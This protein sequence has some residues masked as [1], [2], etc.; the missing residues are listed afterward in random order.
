MF[1]NT[2][3]SIRPKYIFPL[4]CDYG[5]YQVEKNRCGKPKDVHAHEPSDR[6]CVCES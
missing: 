2:R 3:G 5:A 1:P 6:S 4:Y